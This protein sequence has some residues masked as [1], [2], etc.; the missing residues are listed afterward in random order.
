MKFSKGLTVLL[1]AV[2]VQGVSAGELPSIFGE[3]QEQMQVWPLAAG[4]DDWEAPSR[5]VA[6]EP[7]AEY[8]KPEKSPKR[9][10]LLSMLL[11]GAG[12]FYAG[13]KKKAAIFFGIE[14]AAAG[15]YFSWNGK[16]N[17]VE[18]EFR[19]VADEHWD[20]EAYMAWRSTTR[21]IRN[22]SFTHAL[23]CS[24]SV[25]SYLETGKFSG[26][27]SSEVQ[28]Y[29]ELLGKYDQF[30]AGWDDLKDER[31]GNPIG[32]YTEIDSVENVVSELRLDYEV[33]RD[34]SNKY[35]KRATNIAGL[36][37]VNHVISAIDAARTARGR[38]QGVDPATLERRTRFLFTLHQGSRG[39]VPM[40]MAYK[41]FD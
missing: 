33:Q 35:L 9:A 25:D 37:L 39:E 34:D 12:E 8:G 22:N 19:A 32:A 23:P 16:G 6:E 41:P 2:L 31:T 7:M 40:L 26:C 10:F 15:L 13:S 38:A 27:S 20:V 11:P 28:Q 29:Y 1:C 4:G 24:S 18:D 21:A 30:V 3:Q 17:D 5:A 14:A 36:V